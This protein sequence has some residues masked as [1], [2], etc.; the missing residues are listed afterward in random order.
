MKSQEKKEKEKKKKL[1][2]NK[3]R[4]L[5]MGQAIKTS[6]GIIPAAIWMEDPTA[7][8]MVISILLLLNGVQN[9]SGGHLPFTGH[10]DRRHMFRCVSDKR[11]KNQTNKSGRQSGTRRRLVYH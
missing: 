8:P 3:V 2:K 7:T 4:S 10:P 6:K 9:G 5:P 11:Q 1:T